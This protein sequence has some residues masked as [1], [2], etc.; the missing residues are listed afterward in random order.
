[1]TYRTSYRVLECCITALHKKPE[2]INVRA[3]DMWS[4]SIMLYEMETREVPF[5]DLS[6]MEIGMKVKS[7][8]VLINIELEMGIN[9]FWPN[10]IS[11][12]DFCI[13]LSICLSPFCLSVNIVS[14]P[15]CITSPLAISHERR[16]TNLDRINGFKERSKIIA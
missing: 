11:N 3:A 7:T 9:I 5:S 1:M 15:T 16:L 10:C 4:F 12:Q 14:W 2:E 6:A 8:F 13:C